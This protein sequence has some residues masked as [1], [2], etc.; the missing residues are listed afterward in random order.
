MFTTLGR[1]GS[2]GLRK[3]A[4]LVQAV[5]HDRFIVGVVGHGDEGDREAVLIF[6]YRM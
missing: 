1:S 2:H 6:L 3:F 5:S 4:E